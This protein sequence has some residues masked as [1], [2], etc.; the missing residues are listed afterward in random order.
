MKNGS[1]AN[2]PYF[3]RIA[4]D[5]L[6]ADVKE[7]IVFVLLAVNLSDYMVQVGFHNSNLFHNFNLLCFCFVLF[8][9]FIIAQGAELVNPFLNFF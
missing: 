7:L 3:I 4:R 2:D 9:G 8:Y 1:S 6:D 5:F